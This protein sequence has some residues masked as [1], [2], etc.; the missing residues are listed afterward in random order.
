MRPDS[1]LFDCDQSVHALL[2]TEP[3]IASVLELFGE[4]VL[5]KSGQIDRSQLREKVFQHLS[6]RRALEELL[7]PEVRRLCR[8]AQL[9]A[10][11]DPRL[12]VFVADVPLFFENQFPLMH[13]Y[14]L[15]VATTRNTQMARLLRRS[16]Q[17]GHS[18]AEKIID[19]QLPISKK[20]AATDIVIWNGGSPASM[21]RQLNLFLQWIDLPSK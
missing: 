18:A 19:A 16:P 4:S 10:Q 13:D 9:Q 6:L 1:L 20:I 5:D 15:T 14:A 7:H 12:T 11:Q 17:V 21:K 2:T 3:I 8:E